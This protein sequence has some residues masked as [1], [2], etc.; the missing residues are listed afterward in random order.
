MFA[1][2]FRCRRRRTEAER[3]AEIQERYALAITAWDA[4]LGCDRH[5]LTPLQHARWRA[6]V[7]ARNAGLDDDRLHYARH[8]VASGRCGEGEP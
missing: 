2:T 6:W 7:G 3:A 4:A 1:W 8:L 5:G